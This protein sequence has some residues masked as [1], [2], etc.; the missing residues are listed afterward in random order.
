MEAAPRGE[1]GDAQLGLAGRYRGCARH[2]RTPHHAEAGA[3]HRPCRAC[4]VAPARR[5]IGGQGLPAQAA[6]LHA[7]HGPRHRSC[8]A[9]RGAIGPGCTSE[10]QR[11]REPCRRSLARGR[12]ELCCG[13]GCV[14]RSQG[15]CGTGRRHAGVHGCD[16]DR[17]P[18]LPRR[19]PRAA[20]GAAAHAAP[21]LHAC[22]AR[23]RRVVHRRDAGAGR[24]RGA[25]AMR[26]LGGYEPPL[27]RDLQV[28]LL[29]CCARLPRERHRR[30]A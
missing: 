22:G 9:A 1:G 10:P 18:G 27:P 15:R 2:C 21:R 17:P 24:R 13:L 28:S 3:R 23:A 14:R 6:G 30:I 4:A 25:F 11:P 29:Q 12:E 26:K 16:R 8:E 19:R 7:R 20:P 5:C